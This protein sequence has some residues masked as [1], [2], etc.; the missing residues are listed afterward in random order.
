[1]LSP[2]VEFIVCPSRGG[3]PVLC[4]CVCEGG[5]IG[6]YIITLSVRA[7]CTGDLIVCL[8]VVLSL[9]VALGERYIW[10]LK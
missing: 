10:L 6:K 7:A 4:M 2:T 1:M 9:E 3:S 5:G 8:L